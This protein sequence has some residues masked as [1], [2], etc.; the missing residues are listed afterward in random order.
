MCAFGQV[1]PEQAAPHGGD[2]L[3]AVE[4]GLLHFIKL[5]HLDTNSVPLQPRFDGTPA[6]AIYSQRLV[7]IVALFWE[8][9]VIRSRRANNLRGQIGKRGCRP[10]VTFLSPDRSDQAQSIDPD[11]MDL[12]GTTLKNQDSHRQFLN[13]KP[14]EKFLGIIEWF[15]KIDGNEYHMLIFNT[16]I[17]DRQR[18]PSG[19]LLLY[20]VVKTDNES[21]N[22][23]FKKAIDTHSPVYSVRVHP[24]EN[25][26]VYCSGNDLIVLELDPTPSGIK[27]KA[28]CKTTMRSSGR[29]ITIRDSYIYV[30]TANESLQ[31]YRYLDHQLLYWHGDTIARNA[32]CHM[33]CPYSDIILAADMAGSVTGFWQP[34]QHQANNALTT[35]FE[36]ALPRA[37]TRLVQVSR[38]SWTHDTLIPGGVTILEDKTT[39]D[40][41]TPALGRAGTKDCRPRALLGASTDGTITQLLV[42][43][44][45]WRLLKFVQNMCEWNP[46][47][48]PFR[49]TRPKRSLEPTTS[50]PRFM[51]INGDILNRLF[52]RGANR[53]L[54]EMLDEES[55]GRDVQE[56]LMSHESVEQRWKLFGEMSV[57]VLGESNVGNWEREQLVAEA[58]RWMRYVMRSAL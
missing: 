33:H 6:R 17:K 21:I 9:F 46:S 15:P 42:V 54:T 12:D 28:P 51:H 5:N 34:S 32:I 14:G 29:H 25:S 30:S 52:E 26:I 13:H 35:V 2:M 18:P 41:S 39:Y 47:I 16:T 45:G 58:I 23:A 3:V 31:I 44:N 55:P 22:I 24:I 50:N 48:C 27:F 36:A 43:M 40:A 49:T 4:Q 7:M 57:E 37:I 10:F 20:A 56:S 8:T 1:S 11:A 19:R 38:P 53:M